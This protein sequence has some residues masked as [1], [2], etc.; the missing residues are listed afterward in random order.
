[1]ERKQANKFG[2]ISRSDNV[3]Y[4]LSRIYVI[5]IHMSIHSNAL[6]PVKCCPI[7]SVCTS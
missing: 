2:I 1:M 7:T 5:P 4:D 6:I 3:Y